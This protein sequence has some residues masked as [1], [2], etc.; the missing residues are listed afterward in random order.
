MSAMYEIMTGS[1]NVYIGGAR[2]AR[3]GIDN[4]KRDLSQYSH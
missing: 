1:S 2:A 4:G 3:S